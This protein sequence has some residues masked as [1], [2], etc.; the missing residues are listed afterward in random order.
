M[1]QD[2]LQRASMFTTSR[3]ANE[4][5]EVFKKIGEKDAKI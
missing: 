1:I 4:T 3:C 5:L 2:G